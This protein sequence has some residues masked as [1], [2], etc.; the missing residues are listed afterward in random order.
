[1]RHAKFA[2]TIRDL[3]YTEKNVD[4]IRAELKR[5]KLAASDPQEYLMA[6]GYAIHYAD[7]ENTQG[8]ISRIM[9]ALPEDGEIDLSK[10]AEAVFKNSA[11]SNMGILKPLVADMVK[12][13]NGNV[14][15]LAS[16]IAKAVYYSSGSHPQSAVLQSVMSCTKHLSSE[17]NPSP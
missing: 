15:A 2:E 8:A 12:S 13:A 6:V 1:M 7:N 5:I 14:D 9:R 3:A 17:H 10:E 4:V 16:A 11:Q